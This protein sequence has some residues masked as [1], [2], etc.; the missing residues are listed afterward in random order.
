VTGGSNGPGTTPPTTQQ[1]IQTMGTQAAQH[2]L[3]AAAGA[4]ANASNSA[5]IS[6]ARIKKTKS[7][8]W[9]VVRVNSSNATERL[10]IKLVGKSGKTLKKATKTVKTN[11]SVKVMKLSSRVKTAKVSLAK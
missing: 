3:G 7:G 4:K 10:S 11:R 5:R 6:K 9:L 8:R 1:A 2:V